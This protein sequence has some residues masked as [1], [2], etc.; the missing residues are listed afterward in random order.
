M[1]DRPGIADRIM[2][3]ILL[4][5]VT[6]GAA[7]FVGVGVVAAIYLT[8]DIIGHNLRAHGKAL[9]LAA[10][11]ACWVVIFGAVLVWNPDPRR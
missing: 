8:G 1:E 4:A 3:A 5:V 9:Y 2:N 6:G 10:V 11:G 7:I